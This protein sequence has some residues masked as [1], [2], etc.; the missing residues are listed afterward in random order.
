MG[1]P[2]TFET[3]QAELGRLIETF[4]RNFGDYQKP[5]YNE[6]DLRNEFL[7][8]FFVALGWDVSNRAGLAPHAREVRVESRG[9]GSARQRRADY[10]FRMDRQEKF[11]CEAKRPYEELSARYV[12]QAKNYAW[13]RGLPLAVLT[14][15]EEIKLYIVGGRPDLEKPEHGEYRVWRFTEYPQ[16]AQ[17]IWGLLARPSVAGGSIEKLVESLPKRPLK[18]KARQQWLIGP[19]PW[20]SSSCAISTNNAANWPAT[21]TAIIHRARWPAAIN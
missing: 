6:A 17:E 19:A 7:N 12:F 15:F 4:G 3:F 2:A 13:N 16:A 20:T 10:E 1:T 21:S 18:G 8:P 14:D 11:I 5:G 9:E